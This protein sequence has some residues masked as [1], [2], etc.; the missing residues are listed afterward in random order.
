MPSQDKDAGMK[1]NG[2]LAPLITIGTLAEEVGLSVSA[3]RKY[4]NQGLIIAHRTA[5]DRRMF[6][7][8]DISRVRYIHKL[9]QEQSL[10]IEGIRRIQALIPCW[11]IISCKD[12]KRNQCPAFKDHSKPCWTIKGLDCAPQGNECRSCMVYRFGSLC[13]ENI[14][15]LVYHKASFPNAASAIQE[16]MERKKTQ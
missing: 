15:E 9:I 7:Q 3:V 5:S 13:T 11:E 6:S 4:E 16:V 2:S 1:P 10:N 12:S 8:E 14:K